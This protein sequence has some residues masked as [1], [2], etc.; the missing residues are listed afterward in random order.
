MHDH[1]ALDRRALLRG[2]TLGGLGLGLTNLFPAWAQTGSHGH[3]AKAMPTLT[4]NEI[5]LVVDH[6]MF[7]VDG[8]KGHAITINGTIPAPLIRLREGRMSA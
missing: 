5:R 8:R 3:V 1:F 7:D 4:G 2:A 6:G